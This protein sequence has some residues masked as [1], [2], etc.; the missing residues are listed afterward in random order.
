MREMNNLIN[1]TVKLSKKNIML[2][3]LSLAIPLLMMLD[4]CLSANDSS[5]IKVG[6]LSQRI[7]FI[8]TLGYSVDETS[9]RQAEIFVPD[10]FSEAFE[11]FNNDLKAQGFDLHKLE[12]ETIK[13]YTYTTNKEGN[14]SLFVY[15]NILLG[16]D[17]RED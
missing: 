6:Q 12:G 14:I 3:C 13:R 5:K 10:N 15:N 17:I 11:A 9:E 7:E 16:Y 1:L 8:S 4:F 2:L